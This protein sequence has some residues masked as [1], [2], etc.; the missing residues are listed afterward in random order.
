[1]SKN[2]I[3]I[4]ACRVLGVFS[5]VLGILVVPSLVG[6]AFYAGEGE[7]AVV[8]TL[9]F[10]SLLPM[11]AGLF[12]WRYAVPI[13]RRMVRDLAD[14]TDGGAASASRIQAI[15]FSVVGVVVA[16]R[17][18]PNFAAVLIEFAARAE[19]PSWMGD[20][21]FAR[22]GGSLI[23]S[24]LLIL[25]GLA[26]FY[27]GPRLAEIWRRNLRAQSSSTAATSSQSR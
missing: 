3:A 10:L 8:L 21:W 26:L 14:S 17:G 23:E 9:F 18:L 6:T 4:L 25:L 12:L 22:G 27:R 20:S 16:L 5:V 7:L 11:V 1:M 15:A 13:G 2:E 19:D 24:G